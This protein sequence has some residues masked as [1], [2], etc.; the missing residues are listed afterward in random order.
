[1]VK[2]DAP[3]WIYGINSVLALIESHR[4]GV[5]GVYTVQGGKNPR[6]STVRQAAKRNDIPCH[7]KPMQAFE[8]LGSEFAHQ[9]VM[10]LCKLPEYLGERD[11]EDLCDDKGIFLILD[12]V[13]DPANFGACLRNAEAFGATAVIV[14]SR[15]TSQLTPAAVKVASGAVGRIPIVRTPNL[16]RAITALKKSGV[17]IVGAVIGAGQELSGIDCRRP[18]AIAL[19]AEGSGLRKLTAESCDYRATIPLAGKTGSLNVSVASAICLHEIQRQRREV[20]RTRIC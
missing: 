2:E 9:G 20:D 19:G 8:R 1:M 16:S 3:V 14:P 13:T 6:L 12:Q 7:T 10:S 4:E 18:I 15:N 11:L 17:W 5:I